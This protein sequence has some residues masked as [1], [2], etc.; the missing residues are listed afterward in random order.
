M[1]NNA[2]TD[3]SLEL[4]SYTKLLENLK[5]KNSSAAHKAALCT[6]VIDPQKCHLA[7]SLGVHLS[8]PVFIITHSEL[9]AKEMFE[10]MQFFGS[11]GVYLYPSKD[12]VFYNADVRSAHIMKHRF[13]ILDAL[14]NQQQTT[15]IASVEAL[16]D[17]I[18][19]KN[20]FEDFILEFEPGDGVTLDFIAERLVL[21]GY[22]RRDL[23]ESA[24]QFAV[25]G[26]I[27]DL[28]TPIYDNAIRIEFWGDEI[29]SIRL[30]D[31][32]SQRSIEKIDH[33]C[34][35]PMRELVYEEDDIPK[36]IERIKKDFENVKADYV[37]KGLFEEAETLEETINQVVDSFNS[38]KNFSG[39]DK[40][41]QYFYEDGT[42]LIDYLPGN[43][44]IF[45]DEP[46]RI[47]ERAGNVLNE[48]YESMKNR[49][50][51]GYLLPRQGEMMFS[52]ADILAKTKNYA[53]I[54]LSMLTYGMRDF[55][56]DE[57]FSF[58][59]KSSGVIKQRLDMLSEDLRYFKEKDYRI[60]I[61]AGGKTR[62]ERLSAELLDQ[63][64]STKYFDSFKDVSFPKGVVAL[65]RGS[66]TKGFEYPLIRVVIISD[67]E[68]FGAEKEKKRARKKKKGAK[69]ES[70]TDLKIGDYVVHDSHGIGVYKGIEKIIVDG[71]SRDYLK[72]GY[73]NEGNLY[74]NTS[75]LDMVQKYIGGD[76]AK[77]K[78]NKLGGQEWN[79]SKAR[80]RSS[81]QELAK[82][83]VALYA[84]R[85]AATGFSYTG[86][87]V[88][89]KEF[90]E[91]FPFEETEDQ[92]L[93]IEDVKH[94]ME[95]D[96]VMDRLICGDVGYGKTE[97]AI[98]A[99][100]K[101]VQDNKQVAFLVPTTI[102]AQQHY[103]T[104][105]QRMKDFPI[106]IEMLSRFRTPKQQ[107]LAIEGISKG[108][109]DIVIGTHRLLSKDIEFK[110]LGLI[111]VD[112][113]QRFGVSHK[114]RLKQMR[115]NVDVLTLTATPIPRTLHMSLTGIRDMS[116][117]EEPPQERQPIQTY[118]MEYN[119][120]AVRDAINRELA[121]NG[122]VYF[123][124]NHV[125]NI[126]ET[127]AKLQ[128]LVPGAVVSYAHGQMSEHELEHIMIDFIEGEIDVLV[129]TTIIETGLDIPNV[130]TII[131]Q[132]A[133][134]MGL[135]QLY[136]LRGR[137]GRSNRTSYAYLM[138]KKDK[139]LTEL[140]E[141]RLQTIREFTEFG[142]GFKIAMRD[143]E[144]RGAGNLLGGEQHGHMDVVG[145]DT[146]CKLLAEAVDEIKGVPHKESFETTVD[147]NINAFIPGYYIENEE[148]KL[149]VY[150]KISFIQNEEDYYDMQEEI[151]DRYGDLPS[152]VQ[153][154]LEVALLKAIA[155][156]KGITSIAQ[157]SKSV[158]IMFKPNADISP[159]SLASLIRQ[160]SSS[161]F[162]TN[163]QN[164][165][166][167]YKTDCDAADLIPKITE[168][169][170][171]LGNNS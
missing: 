145:Y 154:L 16:F 74:V 163:A 15:I 165:Y 51:K 80:V 134:H 83:L 130:N 64:F 116:I 133:D 157:K 14:L 105:L 150:K 50:S 135:S 29:D 139:V 119:T 143:L 115:E 36:A 18:T 48:F 49:I 69:I 167:T 44:L 62:A 93:A 42:S 106:R 34:I 10:D 39:A 132:D 40:Y 45:F 56:L 168:M 2:L 33:I 20:I 12:A 28:F 137:V 127:A 24:G 53:Q 61:L 108:L 146:Y 68:L 141:K 149:E 71:I 79:K 77:P 155:H 158:V 140:S 160:N 114:E 26:G 110:N 30:M 3:I 125:R 19:P 91:L 100:F 152:S 75:Q 94:D 1:I 162:F 60:I 46:I 82:D 129:C 4:D 92:L 9:K 57:T 112:E 31:S 97:I 70:F 153:N 52:Y 117:L 124:H 159:E 47:S 63:G 41:I 109:V 87:S 65:S 78:L 161:L 166:I 107:K 21:M 103:N 126:S 11:E 76:D 164:P 8:R 121:R 66:L 151:E 169:I 123:L 95:S 89:Q 147:I 88:W 38:Q 98:R 43:T 55:V 5:I 13:K 99:A 148:Q 6:G 37:K 138:Y 7:Y 122:Q 113:E 142:S 81:V 144:I 73:A 171:K 67:K 104:F 85:Q 120:E 59:T 84:K 58:E 23:V 90:E 32:Y 101:A 96:K 136:Q 131:I 128:Q 27:L 54:L 102:L 72:I 111:I 17:R 25:R 22:E 35:F 156:N 118:V 170:K 86:D